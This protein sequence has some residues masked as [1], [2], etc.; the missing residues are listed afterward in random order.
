MSGK[1]SGG[2]DADVSLSAGAKVRKLRFKEK[3]ETQT[4]FRGDVSKRSYSE[5]QRRNLPDEVR[6]GV[7]YRD[8]SIRRE[9][10]GWVA[11]AESG[12]E[13]SPRGG[14]EKT[15]RGHTDDRE[16]TEDGEKQ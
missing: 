10:R 7:E 14:I 16:Q 2:E 11:E 9:A 4:R 12:D 5:S 3:P 1:R 6:K 15:D 13:E 8:A